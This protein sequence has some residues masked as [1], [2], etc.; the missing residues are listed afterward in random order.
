MCVYFGLLTYIVHGVLNNYL[1]TDKASSLFWG[2]IAIM[3]VMDLNTE[4]LNESAA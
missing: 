1:D 4:K 2:F 3:V